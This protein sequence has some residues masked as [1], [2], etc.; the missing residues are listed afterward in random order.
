MK[1]YNLAFRRITAS[2]R[3]LPKD[4]VEIIKKFLDE[5]KNKIE[6]KGYRLNEIFGFD[7]SSFYMDAPGIFS[8]AKKGSKR[9]AAKT[10]GKEKTRLSCLMTATASGRK[11][12]IV[13]I[14][15]RK[16]KI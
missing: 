4:C 1:R 5:V 12:P 8:I 11:L 16:K 9:V 6:D 13:C 10:S 14:V 15:P 3:E 7:E 2:G